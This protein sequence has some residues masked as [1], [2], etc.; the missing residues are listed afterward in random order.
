LETG[1]TGRA[2]A[3]GGLLPA[4]AATTMTARVGAGLR[5]VVCRA[6]VGAGRVVTGCG[7]GLASI[8]T[9]CAGAG[10]ANTCAGD[11]A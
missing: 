11:L 2:A 1:A 7:S 5:A 3:T 10:V 9:T 6:V 8:T 4:G